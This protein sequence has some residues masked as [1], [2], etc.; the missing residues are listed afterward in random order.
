MKANLGQRERTFANC[1]RIN[2][3]NRTTLL[4]AAA[5]S[6][7]GPFLFQF[8]RRNTF[9]AEGEEAFLALA[10]S[11]TRRILIISS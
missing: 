9:G 7:R 2:Y 3:I 8:Q 11:I 4:A 1:F 10:L 6:I 5:A